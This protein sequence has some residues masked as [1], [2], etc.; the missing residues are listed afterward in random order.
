[1]K[2]KLRIGILLD[3]YLIPHWSYRMLEEIRNSSG[4][5]IVLIVKN[6]SGELKKP[7]RFF[8]IFLENRKEIAYLVYRKLDRILF[9]CSPDAFDLKSVSN[10]LSVDTLEITPDK[11]KFCDRISDTDIIEIRKFKIDIFIKLGFGILQGDI[12]KSARYGVWSYN[13]GNSKVDRGSSMEFWEVIRNQDETVVELQILRGDGEAGTLLFK[14]YS[15]TIGF[16]INRNLNNCYWKAISF[17][18]LKIQELFNIGDEKFFKQI[19]DLNKHP[20]F[21]SNQLRNMPSNSLVLLN[22][23]IKIAYSFKAYLNRKIHRNKWILMYCI[24]KSPGISTSLNQFQKMIP[25]KD[26]FWADPHVIKRDDKY[27]VFLEEFIYSK[28]KAH[29]SLVIMD[30]KGDFTEPVKVLERDY[31]LSF[32]FIIEDEG[33]IYMIPETKMN[34][35]IE[36]FKCIEFPFKWELESILFDKISAV[37]STVIKKDGRYWLFTNIRNQDGASINDELFLFSSERLNSNTWQSHPQ[38]PVVSDVRSARPAG[39][40]FNYKGNLY[41]PSQNC[42]KHYGHALTINQVIEMN[43]S[44]YKEI[45]VDSI[46]PVWDK[47]IVGTHTIN[48]IDHLTVIDA[49][50]K[51]G[52]IS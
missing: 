14:S 43:E 22:I 47:E 34:K 10:I 46:F 29:I 36:L 5:E 48:S 9:K 8:K 13:H 51:R 25:P 45:V 32:P 26:R 44:Q 12:L 35:T 23:L 19:D 41:R 6:K 15:H 4:A 3:N 21:Y 39:N 2:E 18:P 52:I 24:N 30:N 49:E 7:K 20:Q 42:S 1:M 27:Y 37:D 11:T 50:M 31:H 28:N 16:S 17:L 33:E 38:N 40:F